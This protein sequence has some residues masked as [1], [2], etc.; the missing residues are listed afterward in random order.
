M[1]DSSPTAFGS[2]INIFLEPRKTF[3]DVRPHTSWLWYPLL[4]CIGS[5]LLVFAWYYGTADWGVIQQQTMD[6]I[7][8]RNYSADQMEQIRN[9]LTRK[10]ILMQT[11]IF[12]TIFVVLIYL[13]QAL[14]LFLVS[15][16]GG[17]EVQGYGNWF[18]FTCWAYMPSVLGNLA[19]AVMYAISGK[20]AAVT[21]LDV[22]SL[23]TLLFKLTPQDSWFGLLNSL[24]LTTFWSFALLVIGFSQ[25]TRQ[26]LGKSAALA[27]APHILIYGIWILV[28]LI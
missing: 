23:N 1:N 9:G 19:F 13:V 20:Q 22:T 8:G 16:I 14:Y 27:L 11:C 5:A 4:L 2:L 3:D 7:A 6:Y 26:S 24:H 15:K 17:Y 21:S 28:K 18:N 10:G 25:W 12:L